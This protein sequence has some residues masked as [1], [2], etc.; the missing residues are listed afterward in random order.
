M[1]LRRADHS[2]RRV[3][4]NVVRRCVWSR[5]IVNEEALSHRGLSHQKQT[6]KQTKNRQKVNLLCCETKCSTSGSPPAPHTTEPCRSAVGRSIWLTAGTITPKQ[7]SFW[8]LKRLSGHPPVTHTW[9]CQQICY[10][11]SV[12]RVTKCNDRTVTGRST[13]LPYIVAERLHPWKETCPAI[14]WPFVA[15]A[16]LN[17]FFV[18]NRQEKVKEEKHCHKKKVSEKCWTFA[19][20]NPSKMATVIRDSAV[21]VSTLT[22][23]YYSPRNRDSA[24]M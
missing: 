13:L 22:E 21:Q 11:N 14:Y 4:L 3:L 1:S 8:T 12:L 15:R 2:S 19:P 23:L 6:N 17:S 7:L 9:C 20:I 5:N 16:K 18:M 24:E 10:Q